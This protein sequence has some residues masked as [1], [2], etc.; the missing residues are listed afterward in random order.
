MKSGYFITFEGGDGSGKS[1]QLKYLGDTLEINGIEMVSTREPGGAPGAEEIRELLVSGSTVKWTP[2]TELLLH[3]GAR[4]DHVDVIVRPA[5]EAGKWVI[6]DRFHD[7]SMAYQGFGHELGSNL[8]DEL[9]ALVLGEFRPDLTF[10]LDLPVELALKRTKQRDGE[11]DRYEQMGLAFHERIRLGFHE[12]A[13]REPARCIL[14]DA[15]KNVNAVY[16]DVLETIN[17][18]LELNLK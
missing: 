11:E 7:S 1:T 17:K 6:S 5:L 13:R 9:H 10:I 18:R 14:V 4:M 3:Y 2:K 8:I 16:S 15:S 12:I